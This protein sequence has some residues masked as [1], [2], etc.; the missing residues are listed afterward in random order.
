MAL[1][2]AVLTG[3]I[4]ARAHP[5]GSRPDGR[6]V[7]TRIRLPSWSRR[8]DPLNQYLGA[9]SRRPVRQAAQD[10]GD[11]SE[12]DHRC[13]NRTCGARPGAAT[14]HRELGLLR[15]RG[16]CRDRGRAGWSTEELVR[17]RDTW[18]VAA[19]SRR[20]GRLRHPGRRGTHLLDRDRRYR[21]SCSAPPMSI[22]HSPRC[23]L[24][25][26]TCIKASNTFASRSWN[27]R[28]R[29]AV[30]KGPT[31]LSTHSL[32]TSPTSTR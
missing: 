14:P 17:R 20:A 2:A 10:S 12:T 22:A 6:A 21:A 25:P 23:I 5:C 29:V 24:G 31:R 11:R 4:R 27:G 16:G 9:P 18:N 32:V 26:S 7:A 1:N 3:W 28:T 19:A 13:W 15:R 8:D 30:V